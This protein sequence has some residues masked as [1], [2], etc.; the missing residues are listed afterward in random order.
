MK[1][2]TNEELIDGI[3]LIV[4]VS[5]ARRTEILERLNKGEIASR[6]VAAI[7]KKIDEWG[8]DEMD[9]KTCLEYIESLLRHRGE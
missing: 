8:D 2:L 4:R 9:M 1:E 5:T 7:Q 3:E 6:L